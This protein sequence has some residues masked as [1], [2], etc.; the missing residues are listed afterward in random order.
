VIT[1]ANPV[2]WWAI[3]LLILGAGWLAW[4]AYART[5]ATL[6]TSRRTTLVGLRFASLLLL[7]LLLMR[8]VVLEPPSVRRDAIVPVLVDASRSMRL[9]DVGDS[10]ASRMD[11]AGS[12][13]RDS[14]LPALRSEFRAEVLTFGERLA[15]A[16]AADLRP[17]DRRSDLSAAIDAVSQRYRGRRWD[18]GV[19]DWCRLGADRQGSRSAWHRGRR[20][21]HG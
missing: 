17:D 9:Q 16:D 5:W 2:A 13:V 4:N 15:P 3:P 1:L 11:L 7:V 10:G 14:V 21:R 12:L 8:P 19:C 6:S 18:T 20:G